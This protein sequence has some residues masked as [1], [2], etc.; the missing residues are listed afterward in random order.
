[1]TPALAG[2]RQM[3]ASSLPGSR[4]PMDMT[5]RFQCHSTGSMR[6]SF[7]PGRLPASL[8]RRGMLG[9]WTSTSSRPVRWP[10]M[11][12]PA[13]RLAATVDLPTPPLPESTTTTALTPSR[14]VGFGFCLI[15]S[16]KSRSPLSFMGVQAPGGLCR[17][18]SGGC[19]PSRGARPGRAGFPG[20]FGAG[21]PGR[22]AHRRRS[23]G[24]RPRRGA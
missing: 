12:S 9:P 20:S 23:R 16:F 3:T 19:V 4:K 11:A 15:S 14:P 8:S 2:P 18:R 6:F 24:R 7:M 1:M 22:A 17:P 5:P 21:R 10:S 13:A